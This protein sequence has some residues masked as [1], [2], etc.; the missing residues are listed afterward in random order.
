[1]NRQ[2]IFDI[3]REL[4]GRGF[5]R[6]EVARIDDAI[7]LATG[8]IAGAASPSPE[9]AGPVPKHLRLGREGRALIRQWEGCHKRRADGRY[10]AYP[11]P[12][13]AD[14]HPW[15]IGWGSTGPGIARGTVWTQEQ[16]D[17]RFDRDLER[18][19]AEVERALGLA[20]TTQSQFDALVSFHYNTGA[21]SR[22]T[23]TKHHRA[24][25]HETAAREFGRWIYNNRKPLAGLVN[26]RRAEAAL[27][28]KC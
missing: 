21:I 9:P 26:R 24:G 27:Y 3:V 17:T 7:D 20:P 16:C 11:D 14:G 8:T 18:Y 4:L 22:A 23:L 5:S 19:A 12:G 1:M 6:A 2:P 10:A 13:S 28:R 15:T 25:D